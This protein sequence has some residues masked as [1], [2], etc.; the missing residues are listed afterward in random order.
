MK[1][2]FS[3][4]IILVVILLFVLAPVG[5]YYLVNSQNPDSVKGMSTSSSDGNG[6]VFYITSN[7]GT[8][9]LSEY[10]CKDMTE[11]VRGLTSGE[12]FGQ[13]SGGTTTDHEVYISYSDNWKNYEYMKVYITPGWGTSNREYFVSQTVGEIQTL[14]SDGNEKVLIIPLNRDES[15]RV[16]EV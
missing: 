1:G 10:L 9:D 7:G 2:G 3:V 16:V 5:Y 11:W 15:N 6:F 14:Q 13:I 8:W 12:L 4:P